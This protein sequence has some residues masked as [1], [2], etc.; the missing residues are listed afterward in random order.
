[1]FYS[2]FKCRLAIAG[3]FLFGAVASG[4]AVTLLPQE[5]AIA[6]YMINDPNQ[7]RPNLVLDPII[8][9]VARARAQD[10]A[11]RNYFGHVNPDGVAANYLLTQAGYQLPSWWGADPTANYVESIAAGTS[12]AS[13]TWQAWMNS[14]PHK[15][16]LLGQNS[17]FAGETHYGV[18]YYYDP[19]STYQYYW[20]VITAPPQPLEITTPE[21]SAQVAGTGVA[22]AG[23]ADPG[24]NV[25]SVQF[26][27]ENTTGTS[28]YQTATG[29][30][31]WSGTAAGLV[32]GTNIIRAQS[33]DSSGKL[34]DEV[35]RAVKDVVAG[36][37]SVTVSGSGSVTSGFEGVTTRAVGDP[38]TIKATPAPGC[39]FAGWTGSMI[40][41]SPSVTFTMQDGFNLQANFVPNPFIAAGGAHYGILTTG[42]GAQAGLARLT[43]STSGYFSGRLFLSGSA[44]SFT[45]AFDS[46]GAATVSI[47]PFSVTLQADLTGGSGQVTGTVS[48][49]T[50]TFT[51]TASQSAFNATTNAAPQ[52]GRYTLALAPDPSATGA[53]VPQ[54]SG[55]AAV[56]VAAN[57]VATVAGRLADG[58]PYSATGHVANDGTLALYC[59]PS[60]APAGSSLNGLL[61]FRATNVSDLDGALTW[62]KAPQAS[63]PFYPAGFTAQLPAAGSHYVRPASGLQPLNVPSGAATAG[64][65][66]G[67]LAQPMSV[68][69]TVNQSDEATMVTPG[70]PDL[71][72]RIN[73]VSGTV[74]GSFVLPQ[75][76]VLRGLRGVVLQKQQ[77]AFG[78]FRGIDQCGYFSLSGGS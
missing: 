35:T 28:A 75:G 52:A 18:G 2:S 6:N 61:T 49:G 53:S 38:V 54:G 66:D 24:S 44:W 67:N 42:S 32:P 13:A 43:V 1:M 9:G 56:V 65:G 71:T 33:L 37:L 39:L 31:S 36:T 60:G 25:A 76:N 40:S 10:M 74:S 26:R 55:Y 15:V 77:A 21:P 78:Y 4:L 50:D 7:G 3:L 57:G 19:N 16:D 72:F 48:D 23:T 12:S 34:I 64:F 11:Q 14:P 27:I 68:P 47:P 45:G 30:A 69:V 5:Q 70:S 20:V 51:F 63:A 8:E 29:I 73:P 58:A 17:F 62:K 41:G 59:V 46:T 22:V